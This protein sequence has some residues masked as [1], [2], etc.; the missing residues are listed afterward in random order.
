[1][2]DLE[3]YMGYTVD[4]GYELYACELLDGTLKI[5]KNMH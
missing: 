2:S 4:T 3:G 1:M 5:L